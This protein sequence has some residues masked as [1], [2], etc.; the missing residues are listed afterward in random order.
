MANDPYAKFA[1]YYDM[2][3][4][5]KLD[6]PTEVKWLIQT[7]R[8][9]GR[10]IHSVLDL[11]CGTG[12]HAIRLASKGYEVIG[13]DRSR[14]M[15]KVARRNAK[16]KGV[17]LKFVHGDMSSFSLGRTFDAVICMFGGWGYM[18]KTSE[19]KKALRRVQKHLEPG[20]LFIVEFWSIG[21]VKPISRFWD[22]YKKDVNL[23]RFTE[24]TFDQRKNR[25][26]I[27]MHHLV[28]RGK[29]VIDEFTT[30]HVTRGYRLSEMRKFLTSAN[31]KVHS[32]LNFRGPRKSYVKAG[33]KDFNIVA[34]TTV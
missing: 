18:L 25:F 12:G 14:E 21:G 17:K 23:L 4:E 7:F 5:Q 22:F 3:Y 10:N 31:F 1:K 8:N 19:V 2:L 13:V 27:M 33:P 26:T 29:R 20:G 9:Y 34:I 24:N 15:L 16:R 6:Y 28:Y 30:R 11:G 32:M